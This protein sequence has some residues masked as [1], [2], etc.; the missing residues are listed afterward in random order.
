MFSFEFSKL[1]PLKIETRFGLADIKAIV[2][3]FRTREYN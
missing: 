3:E 1:V 2:A